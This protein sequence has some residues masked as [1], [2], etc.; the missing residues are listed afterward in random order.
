M[1]FVYLLQEI[2]NSDK[3]QLDVR[4][5]ACIYLKNGFERQ[6]SRKYPRSRFLGLI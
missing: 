3:V 6:W 2:V 4:L 1:P 5:L